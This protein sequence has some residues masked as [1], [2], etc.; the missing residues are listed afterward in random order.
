MS[1]LFKNIPPELI[2]AIKTS[3]EKSGID[4]DK[5]NSFEDSVKKVE[6]AKETA[7][8]LKLNSMSPKKRALFISELIQ[9]SSSTSI[10]EHET[11]VEL[12]TIFLVRT[13]HH[14]KKDHDTLMDAA[15]DN[16]NVFGETIN[17]NLKEFEATLKESGR[18][19]MAN[20]MYRK[21][22]KRG[23]EP[24]NCPICKA[25]RSFTEKMDA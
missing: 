14:L 5:L 10:E 21:E 4:T 17:T 3:L 23:D 20:T 6:Q 19:E 25:R 8:N 13:G 2:D 9:A 22:R 12:A 15:F 16:Y 11:M 7:E 24:C 1:N 18:E